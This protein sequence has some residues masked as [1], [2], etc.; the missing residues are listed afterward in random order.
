[1]VEKGDN[2]YFDISFPESVQ[3][4]AAQFISSTTLGSAM[5]PRQKFE[6]MN[7]NPIV[8]DTDYLENKRQLPTPDPG[9]LL[10]ILMQKGKIKVCWYS[11]LKMNRVSTVFLVN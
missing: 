4:P 5:M 3:L 11:I 7:A 9:P 1:L 8:F 2:V 10:N 6:D